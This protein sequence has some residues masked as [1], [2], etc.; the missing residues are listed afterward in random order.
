MTNKLIADIYEKFVHNFYTT[1]NIMK[2]CKHGHDDKL[3][4]NPCHLENDVWTHTCM[5]FSHLNRFFDDAKIDDAEIQKISAI[6][7]LLHDVGKPD[8][9]ILTDKNRI[10]FYGHEKFS[11]SFIINNSLKL[12]ELFSLT[13]ENILELLLVIQ[14]HTLYYQLKNIEDIFK[15]LNYNKKNLKIFYI[16]NSCDKAGRIFNNDKK[17][18]YS[19]VNILEIS[20]QKPVNK[21]IDKE[22][23]LL[24]G[25][26]ASGKNTIINEYNTI[27][28]AIISLDDCRIKEYVKH[29]NILEPIPI[30]EQH[31]VYNAAYLWCKE[32]NVDLYS[33]INKQLNIAIKNSNIKTIIINNTNIT[34]S[35]RRSFLATARAHNLKVSAICLLEKM[36][37]LVDRDEKR[38]DKHVGENVILN[39]FGI[40][41]LPTY[42]ESFDSIKY[43][44]NGNPL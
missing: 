39:M 31:T 30:E 26:P 27:D 38:Y 14:A 2:D 8:C 43:F 7:V 5:A 41:T 40:F 29:F 25:L 15:H 9:R 37:V 6:A 44:M 22:L 1:I 36:D 21:N 33:K 11:N 35:R 17:A 16:L 12:K 20:T 10:A 13:D 18:F 4:L 32:K 34:V 23:I 3:N 42:N 19:D 24:I 28:T